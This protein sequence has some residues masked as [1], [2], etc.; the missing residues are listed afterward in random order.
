[1]SSSVPVPSSSHSLKLSEGCVQH[2]LF[3]TQPSCE[4]SQSF[5]DSFLFITPSHK[6]PPPPNELYTAFSF[7]VSYCVPF[8]S[9][10]ILKGG[11]AWNAGTCLFM[12]WTGLGCLMQGINSI[13]WSKNMIDKAP[14]YCDISTR[15]QVGLNAALPACTLCINRRLYKISTAKA[16][17]PTGAEKRRAVITDLLI[18]LGVPI[19]QMISQYVVSGH[20]YNLLEDFGPYQT[21]VRMW[22]SFLF[23]W[24]W[25]LVIGIVSCTYAVRAM[26]AFYR[27]QQR[28]KEIM[29]SNSGLSRG[30][31]IRLMILSSMDLLG[32]IPL[33]LYYIV[34]DAKRGMIPWKSW[35]DTHSHY[36][37]VIQVPAFIWKK[38][39]DSAQALEMYRWSLVLCAFVF[40][41]FFG[42]AE[43]ARQNYRRVFTSLASRVGYLTSSGT[44]SGA[45]S[46]PTSSLPHIERKGGVVVHVV[47]TSGE[48]CSS[49][50]LSSDQL[51]ISSIPTNDE[52]KSDFTTEQYLQSVSIGSSS[53]VNLEPELQAQS[54]ESAVTSMPAVPPTSI[55]PHLPD[56]IK[57]TT[58]AYSSDAIDRV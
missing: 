37:R 50:A 36:H 51:S 19:L 8:P 16:V 20:R 21:T 18:G 58:R 45:S 44:F 11:S 5:R 24:G 10:G 57:P 9:T 23:F 28:F 56:T 35:Q 34:K 12:A 52:F 25:P 6:M 15:I 42:F 7:M 49:S 1:M 40:F 13:V 38:D 33:S 17:M 46:N 4:S 31:Y 26:Y 55:P 41:A 27:R 2:S 48:K 47:T 22:P 3:L 14:V 54:I 29:A 30:R 43:E 32:T 53:V 39:R